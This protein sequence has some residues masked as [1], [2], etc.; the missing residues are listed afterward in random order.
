MYVMQFMNKFSCC[1]G[2][3]T[4]LILR[5]NGRLL[6]DKIVAGFTHVSGYDR[7]WYAR[8]WINRFFTPTSNNRVH[9]FSPIKKP[10][11]S[12]VKLLIFHFFHLAYYCYNYILIK[13]RTR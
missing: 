8:Q 10:L 13:E 9:Q 1:G 11:F 3:K 4:V 7:F 6:M 12:S 5:Q 2:G